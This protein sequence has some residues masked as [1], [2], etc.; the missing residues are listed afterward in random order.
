M[1]QVDRIKP[2]VKA[3]GTKRLKL[4]FDEQHS[5]FAFNFH[6]RRYI[7]ELMPLGSLHSLLHGR[8]LHSS[9]SQLNLSRF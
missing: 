6:L 8:G 3:P 2:A 7:T 5:I 4:K 1:V 9:T